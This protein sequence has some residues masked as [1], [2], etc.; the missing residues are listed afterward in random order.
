[1]DQ[2]RKILFDQNGVKV[3]LSYYRAEDD[4]SL[5][6]HDHLQVSWLL[7]GDLLET[8]RTQDRELL[9]PSIGVK[10]AGFAHANK[11]GRHGSLILTVAIKPGSSME[12]IY[13]R[14][15]DWQW[16]PVSDG[17]NSAYS[18]AHLIQLINQT[19]DEAESAIWDLLAV[20]SSRHTPVL[21]SPPPW[22]LRIRDQLQEQTSPQ[23]MRVMAGEAGVHRV[24]LS[25]I[26][27]ACFG[28]P[29][30]VYRSRCRVAKAL[31]S[32][33]R[34]ETLAGAALDAGFADQSHFNRQVKTQ[35]GLSPRA[36][37]QLVCA[38]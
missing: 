10:P 6:D 30:S 22:L 12:D 37:H 15:N 27:T 7:A 33:F 16:T 20:P 19:D 34:G 3:S 24:Y 5:H 31:S 23:D 21:K 9:L 11:Y 4:M 32:V 1:M 26:F 13:R 17:M 36:L 28:A 2:S 35:T 18:P 38:A 8:N 25:R 29:P 14:L